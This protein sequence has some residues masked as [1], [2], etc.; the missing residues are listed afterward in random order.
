M[1]QNDFNS[2]LRPQIKIL[3][4]LFTLQLLILPT[5][6]PFY[7]Q[8]SYNWKQKLSFLNFTFS[9]KFTMKRV[10]IPVKKLKCKHLIFCSYFKL[11]W[12]WNGF[13]VG[14][15][16][17]WRVKSGLRIS[18][19]GHVTEIYK[20]CLPI[21]SYKPIVHC[22]AVPVGSPVDCLLTNPDCLLLLL[23]QYAGRSDL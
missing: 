7:G 1:G 8:K 12:A 22:R 10:I 6:D 5:R 2:V 17:S 11:F 14:K 9:S 20:L 4:T 23:H 19:G 13:L 21:P 18:I 16:K 3:S 15:I